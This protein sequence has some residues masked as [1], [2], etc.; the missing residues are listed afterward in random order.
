[1]SMDGYGP[2]ALARIHPRYRTPVTAILAVSIVS[3][4]LALSGS[5]VGLALLSV[6]ARLTAYLAVSASVLVLRKRHGDRTEAL[7]LPGGPLIPCAAFLLSLGLLTSAGW[8]NLAAAALAVIAG[9]LIYRFWRRPV[10]EN[11]D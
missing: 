3:L 10:A 11:A 4:V 9:A 8:A 2:A 5:F 6:V 7:R 1:L